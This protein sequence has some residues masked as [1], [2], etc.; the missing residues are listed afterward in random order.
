MTE[1]SPDLA[2]EF[3]DAM[4]SA[5][6]M[7][8]R[9]V[10]EPYANDLEFVRRYELKIDGRAFDFEGYKHLAEVF[11]DDHPEQVLMAGAQTGKSARL[12]ARFLRT[13][14][15]NWG[16]LLGYYFPDQP[17]AAAFSSQRFTPFVKSSATLR[18]Y[19]GNRVVADKNGAGEK[20]SDQVF[21]RSFGASTFFFMSVKGKTSTEGLPMK[22]VFFDEV[23]RM[24][25][26]D[27]QRAEERTSAQHDPINIKVSTA[28]YP[29]SD[30]HA[31]F[32][33][34]DQRYFH[35]ECGCADGCV[36]ALNYP[37]CIAD[38]KTAT[39]LLKAKVAHAFQHAGLPYL[40]MT[41]KQIAQYGEAAYLCPK[42]GNIITDP[43]NGWWEA[44]NPGVWV[45]SY[46][47]PQLISPTYSA[48]RCLSKA[49][50]PNEPVD[51]QEIWNSMV[52]LPYID[53]ERQPVQPEHLA[54]CVSSEARWAM[55]QSDAWRRK[56]VKN[57][58]L[59]MDCQGGYNV[60]VIKQLAPNGKYR[61]IH[62]EIVHGDDPWKE[63]AKL[64][65]RFDVRVAVVDS[66]PHW[67]EAHRFAKAFEGRVWLSVYTGGKA[68]MVDWKDREVAPAGQRKAGEEAKWKFNVHINRTKGLQWSLAR[69][70][71]RLNEVPDPNG[72]IQ[73][74]P[75]QG[76]KVMLTAGLRVGR[77]SPVPICAEVYF[78][79]LQCVAFRKEYASEDAE[80]RGEYKVVADH[81]GLDPHFAHA[82]L[83]ADVAASR[84]GRP[85]RPR[86]AG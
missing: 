84:I 55:R 11:E 16:A 21:T 25:Y 26:G 47:M 43:R 73:M 81:V 54:A 60:I 24:A 63:T 28:F 10:I 68:P 46:Q 17:L 3:T 8:D 7:V 14:I 67:N 30:I 53:K 48:A 59:G 27:M 1:V 23:R 76:G 29:N 74:L 52:G 2:K 40:G 31:A 64:M 9:P 33:R 69:W 86:P 62:L 19:L 56:Y 58:S 83:Y 51:V 32:M 72:L 85:A 6:G 22:G 65:E 4:L 82:N 38:L 35:T 13:G 80:R 12:L 5:F 44:H 79:H 42:C 78:E 57:T 41:E 61:T 36:L 20:G 18:P 45:H 37:N 50:R 66:A 70:K 39:P 15:I 49:E 71:R 77:M 75:R 34:G